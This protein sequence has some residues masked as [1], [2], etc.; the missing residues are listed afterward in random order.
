MTAL[1]FVR[2]IHKRLTLGLATILLL[3]SC[4]GAATPPAQGGPA[5]DGGGRGAGRGGGGAVAVTTGTVLE[6]S[7]PVNIRVVGNVEAS[8]TVDVRSLVTGQ[9]LK[10]EFREGDDVAVGDLLFTIDPRPFEVAVQQ[11]EAMLARDTANQKNAE[12]QRTRYANLLKDGLI[13]Q[14]DYD[15]VATQ[16]AALQAS[17]A[18]DKAAVDNAKLQL[19]Y[20]RI[21]APV[22]GRTGALLVHEG[23]V[24]RVNDAAPMVVIKQVSPIDVSFAVPARLLPQ[25]RNGARRDLSVTAT[26]SGEATVVSEG[27]LSF[28][29]NAVD[30]ATDTIRLKAS[31]PNKDR[32]LWPGAFVDVTMR[33][34]VTSKAIVVPTVAVQPSQQGLFIYVVKSDQTVEARPVKVAWT[35]GTES[36]I[37]TGVTP[38]ETIVIDG[39]LR[40]APGSRITVKPATTS[41]A[42]AP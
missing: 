40:L 17:M 20:T 13:S 35:E 2:P 4:S 15:T 30:P 34:S 12:A 5:A 23:A 9:L 27:S 6:K 25:L 31:F 33:L 10:T 41:E 3:T 26:P 18:A 22:A 24:V 42:G 16:A 1:T 36:V 14:A 32:R 38:G 39:Q 28:L 21:V 19:Q 29:D 8:S 7:M 37:S 11:A